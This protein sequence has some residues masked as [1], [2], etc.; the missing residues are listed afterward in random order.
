ML[1]VVIV[2]A[3]RGSR[4]GDLTNE[5]PKCLVKYK[6]IPILDYTLQSLSKLENYRLC[7]VTG[8]RSDSL[9]KYPGIKV[10]NPD[11]ESTNMVHSFL[12]AHEFFDDKVILLYGDIIFNPYIIDKLMI[13]TEDC[14]LPVNMQY[15]DLWKAR[16]EDPLSDLETLK[17]D[18]NGFLKEIGTVPKSFLDIES[19]YMGIISFS[20]KGIKRF[21]ALCD[22]LKAENESTFKMISMTDLINTLIKKDFHV[23]TLP[24]PGG[25][26]EFD[27]PEDLSLPS[28]YLDIPKHP[29]NRS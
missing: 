23:K 25:W 27:T 26:M 28:D 13:Q 24:I 10:F 6:G 3:G 17:I 18:S 14:I 1:T 12:K 21:K 11:W 8:Y 29:F 9:D 7:L 2:V 4:L 19:Q 20:S 5:V 16:L 15:M 22:S